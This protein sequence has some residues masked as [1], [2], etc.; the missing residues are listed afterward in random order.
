MATPDPMKVVREFVAALRA[1][2][3][4][5]LTTLL[6]DDFVGHVTTT[7][8]GV[9]DANRAEY[10]ASVPSMDVSS[11]PLRPGAPNLVEVER[12]K[13]LIMI[14]VEIEATVDTKGDEQPRHNFSGQLA[15]VVGDQIT[16]LWLVDALP[17]ER[18]DF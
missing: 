10:L 6:A 15:T 11:A 1:G 3:L 4:D 16:E 2:N 14:E 18:D 5:A 8:G 13:V 7:D 12:A 17:S 9:R